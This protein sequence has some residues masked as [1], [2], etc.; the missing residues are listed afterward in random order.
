MNERT[1]GDIGRMI[2]L[3]RVLLLLLP[4]VLFL[5]WIWARRRA[6]QRGENLA[7]LDYKVAGLLGLAII[8]IL[9]IA[10]FGISDDAG[11]RNAIYIA[12]HVNEE[13]EVV[14]GRFVDPE[15]VAK[16]EDVDDPN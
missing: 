10:W 5:L 1:S 15:D 2:I 9:V 7:K 13:G 8:A 4:L 11:D 6:Q 12:P 3:L 16:E 14:P